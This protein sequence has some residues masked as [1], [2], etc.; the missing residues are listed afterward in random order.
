MYTPEK[1]ASEQEK[2]RTIL[3]SEF[4]KKVVFRN[5]QLM[6]SKQT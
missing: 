6:H 4:L 3:H 2:W 5:D 1:R